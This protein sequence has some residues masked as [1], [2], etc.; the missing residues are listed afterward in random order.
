MVINTE[1][2][3]IFVHV[4][5]VAGTSMMRCLSSMPGNNKR[6]L[7][8]RTKHETLAEFDQSIESRRSVIDRVLRRS[9]EG[10]YRF[11][12]VRNPWDRMASLYRYLA[13][14]RKLKHMVTIES[15]K[16]F[17]KQ[18]QEGVEWIEKLHS[19]KQQ[20]DYMTGPNGQMKLDFLGHLE[21]LSE[22]IAALEAEL[23]IRI[24][25]PAL[26]TSSN[27]KRDYKDVYDDEMV[28]IVA[29]RFVDDLQHFGYSFEKRE[30]G[31]RCSGRFDTQR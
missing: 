17:L 10:Y 24:D 15:F 1:H 3:F 29:S 5:K 27:T 25:L 19:M 6:W 9:P 30:P 11:G 14:N 2:Q 28:E 7:S 22:D 13:E 26:N 12:F 16:D 23:G 21:Y 31:K 18:S 20:V 8:R 4:P